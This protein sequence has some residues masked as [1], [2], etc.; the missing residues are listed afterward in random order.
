MKSEAVRA[1]PAWA[2]S[3]LEAEGIT[4]RFQEGPL[5]VT[6]LQGVDLAVQAGET[7]AIVNELFA[8]DFDM[9]GYRS[10]ARLPHGSV[11]LRAERSSHAL[12]QQTQ[13][14]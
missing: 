7:L 4:K 12:Q 11:D 3:I 9:F 8:S 1:D 5:D 14:S 13:G 2:G 10:F 6:V